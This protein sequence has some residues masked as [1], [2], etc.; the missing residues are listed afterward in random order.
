MSS[1]Q[2][3]IAYGDVRILS[4]LIRKVIVSMTRMRIIGEK[5]CLKGEIMSSAGDHLNLKSLMFPQKRTSG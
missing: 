2:N 1:S 5:T 3:R 4:Q